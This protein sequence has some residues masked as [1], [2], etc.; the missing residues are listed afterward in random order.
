VRK[1]T[2]PQRLRGLAAENLDEE[3]AADSKLT[4]L[5]DGQPQG[6]L[7]ATRPAG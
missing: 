5:A 2:R 3:K 1:A 4:S 7:N 6:G